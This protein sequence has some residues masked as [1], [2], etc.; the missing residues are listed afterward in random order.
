MSTQIYMDKR[1]VCYEGKAQGVSEEI[2]WGTS[3]DFGVIQDFPQ[4]VTFD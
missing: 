2:K 1:D 4:E 3:S